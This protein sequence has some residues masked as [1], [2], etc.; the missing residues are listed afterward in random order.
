MRQFKFSKFKSKPK[1]ISQQM[2]KSKPAPPKRPLSG[3]FRF[4]GD[5]YPKVKEENPDL[6]PKEIM[7]K[8]GKMWQALPDKRKDAYNAAY[9]KDKKAFESKKAAFEKKYGKIKRKYRKKKSYSI[10]SEDDDP[11]RPDPPKRPIT[12]FFRFIKEVNE[13]FKKKFP[14]SSRNDLIRKMGDAW[15]GKSESQKL[16]YHK[17]YEKDKKLYFKTLET[18]IKK[19]GK[20]KRMRRFRRSARK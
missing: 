7:S 10:Y 1:V 19:W 16:K 3:Y 5:V 6:A 13:K 9:Q 17:T 15:K 14:G 12:D 2:S 4:R 18:Y 20:P 8:I 11:N